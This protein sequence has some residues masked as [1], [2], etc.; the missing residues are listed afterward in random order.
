MGYAR[1]RRVT[2]VPYLLHPN[3][4][5]PGFI[6]NIRYLSSLRDETE[7]FAHIKKKAVVRRVSRPTARTN[8]AVDGPTLKPVAED[9]IRSES[10]NDRRAAVIALGARRNES[11]VPIIGDLLK[12]ETNK[13]VR[14][15]AIKALGSIG[16]ELAVTLLE[17][18]WFES[19]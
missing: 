5:V 4:N 15:S 7:F 1:G 18:I 10:T 13:G 17:G 14:E 12:T 2:I 3:M 19:E 9:Q 16:G 8:D 11:S 6:A